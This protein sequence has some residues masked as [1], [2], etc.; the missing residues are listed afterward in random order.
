MG[1]QFNPAP[2]W[3]S[4]PADW[5]PPPG[6]RPDP[7]WPQPPPGWKLWI[8]DAQPA[9][10]SPGEALPRRR[11]PSAVRRAIARNT[12]LAV[13]ASVIGAVGFHSM[14]K[15]RTEFASLVT[16]FLGALIYFWILRI[17]A[18]LLELYITK[19]QTRRWVYWPHGAAVAIAIVSIAGDNSHLYRGDN[20]ANLL[21]FQA[22]TFAL[23]EYLLCALIFLL[24]TAAMVLIKR[25]F[26]GRRID[27][28]G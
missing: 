12:I 9:S 21:T 10:F 19:T 3:P 26:A 8:D 14:T 4:P 15:E 18:A 5:R 22:V 20:F 23:L 17:L 27:T 16:G 7:T 1:Q 13:A 11:I 24:L 28:G 6:W 2:G 25:R